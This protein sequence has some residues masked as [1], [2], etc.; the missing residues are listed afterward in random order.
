M[1][2]KVKEL[3]IENFDI[4]PET[5]A[6]AEALS[7]LKAG[8][9][10]VVMDSNGKPFALIIEED[11]RQTGSRASKLKYAVLPLAIIVGSEVE[12]QTLADSDAFTLFDDAGVRGAV[13]T[14]DKGIVM[15]VL[16]SDAI[17]DYLGIADYK[18][19]KITRKFLVGSATAGD[20]V[21]GGELQT[22]LG[23]VR[24]QRCGFINQIYF[25]D[26]KNPPHCQNTQEDHTLVLS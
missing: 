8:N 2:I 10:G 11:I 4:I 1:G 19:S 25:L 9:Y 22:P 13:V 14:G 5:L 23:R 16:T 15:G 20:A 18:L 6:P 21:L 26:R 24:C 7:L 3:M 17:T 12:M